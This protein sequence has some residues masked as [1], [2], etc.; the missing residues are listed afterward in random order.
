VFALEWLVPSIVPNMLARQSHPRTTH[1]MEWGHGYPRN[2]LVSALGQKPTF[3]L[4]NAMSAFPHKQ[5]CAVH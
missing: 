5:T 3:A 1:A 2:D 4:K